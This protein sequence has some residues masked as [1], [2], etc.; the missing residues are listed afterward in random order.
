VQA[1]W[2]SDEVTPVAAG[3]PSFGTLPFVRRDLYAYCEISRQLLLQS[4]A[5]QVVSEELNR[6]IGAELDKQILGGAGTGGTPL[7]LVNYP[8]IGTFTGT[9]LNYAALVAA[10]AQVSTAN[11]VLN[12]TRLGW[13][14]TPAVAALLKQRYR[15]SGGELPL[16]AGQLVAGDIEAAPAYSS[17]DVPSATLI[18]GDWSQLLLAQWP[19]G[20]SIATDPFSNGKFQTAIIGV[21]ACISI[22]VQLRTPAAFSVATGI[23]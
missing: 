9:S 7:G 3:P 6:A 16:W 18:F 23:T 20:L 12:A 22:D 5:D 1:Y 14:G 8:G 17:M 10:M 15:V 13:A 21:R 4:N 2:Q 11:A 19:D